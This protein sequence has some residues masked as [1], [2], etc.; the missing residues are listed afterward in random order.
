MTSTASPKSASR[1]IS[2][3]APLRSTVSLALAVAMFSTACA[4]SE[5][6]LSASGWDAGSSHDDAGSR[7]ADG[8]SE[9]SSSPQDSGPNASD[10]SASSCGDGVCAATE[11]PARCPSDCQWP[12]ISGTGTR[13]PWFGGTSF[14]LGANVAWWNWGQD[15]GGGTS[16]GVASASAAS[17]IRARF[18]QARNAGFRVLR[19]WLFPDSAPVQRDGDNAPTGIAPAVYADLDAALKIADDLDLYYVFV[20]FNGKDLPA[21]WI[22]DSA[23][24]AKLAQVLGGM[25]SRYKDNRR[26]VSWEVMNEPEFLQDNLGI[27]TAA[28]RPFMKAIVDSIHA[29]SHAFATIGAGSTDWVGNWVGL[30]L[31]YYQGHW[32]S[33][34]ASIPSS[35]SDYQ[36]RFNLDR[37]LVIGEFNGG[38]DQPALDNYESLYKNGFSGA[39]PWSLFTEHA[40]DSYEVDYAAAASFSAKHADLGPK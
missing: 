36:S 6:E 35:Y 14:W 39:W 16:S 22:T 3:L 20:V 25:F 7:G 4:G 33:E 15:F 11:T 31:D 9:A 13:V 26:I 38:P 1:R 23:Q 18:Q 8:A 32:Y 27:S 21:S 17:T 28:S 5:G 10:G 34:Y 2:G 24:T 40:G 37:P 29:N 30:G 19:W 12:T